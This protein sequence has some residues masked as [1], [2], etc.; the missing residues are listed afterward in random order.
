MSGPRYF[1]VIPAAGRSVRMGSPKL[2]LPWQ[3]KRVIDHLLAHYQASR[4]EHVV[5]V[6]HPDDH[7]LIAAAEAGGAQVIAHSPPPVDMKESVQ[8]GLRAIESRC[9]PGPLD[10]W[11]L[12]PAD[13]PL[14]SAAVIDAV[15][16]ADTPTTEVLLPVRGEQ[17]GHPVLF[18]WPLHQAV[19]DLPANRGVNA[20]LRDRQPH[21]VE[22]ADEGAYQDIDTFDVY[23]RL[24][25]DAETND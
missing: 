9:S 1:A 5:L 11:L 20:L 4:V 19:F 24:K 22:I 12:A 10:G 16:A 6:A 25:Q 3:G 13:M 14:L 18:R 23:S 2:L 7:E 17:R 21:T 8:R 15:I